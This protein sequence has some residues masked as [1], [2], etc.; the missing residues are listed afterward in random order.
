M[1]KTKGTVCTVGD[2]LE[3]TKGYGEFE[4]GDKFLI[5]GT[6]CEIKD[7]T[8]KRLH[9]NRR[10]YRTKMVDTVIWSLYGDGAEYRKTSEDLQEM[11]VLGL[12]VA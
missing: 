10:D 5:D 3:A 12:M 9:N 8:V 4:I 11:Q 2:Y 6:I 7:Y 1:A